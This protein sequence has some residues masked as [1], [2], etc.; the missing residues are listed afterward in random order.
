HAN[1]ARISP[2]VACNLLDTG[3][4]LASPSEAGGEPMPHSHLDDPRTRLRHHTALIVGAAILAGSASEA[5]EELVELSQDDA[6]WVMPAKNYASQRYSG[7][8]QINSE[9][10]QDLAVAWTF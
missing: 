2:R 3:P 9:N 8:D 1:I 10:V 4:N 7:L 6:Q 5:S